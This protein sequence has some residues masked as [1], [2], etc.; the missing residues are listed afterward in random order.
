V[1]S[2]SVAERSTRS[3]AAEAPLTLTEEPPRSLSAFDQA[4]LW[5]N[6]G[7]TLTLPLA[8]LFVV[9]PI[10]DQPALSIV[11]AAVAIVVGVGLG[12]IVLG[13]S[14]VPGADTGAPAMVVLRGLL[15]RW[16]SVV[17]TAAN[18]A[19][20]VGWA[21]VE[22]F[23]IAVAAHGIYDS[24]PK[25]AYIVMAGVAATLLA[26]R[27]LGFIRS[28]RRYA[29]WLIL[30][31]TAYLFVAVI[32]RGL[33]SLTDGS[34]HQF[35]LAVDIAIALPI[36]WAPLAADYS[37]HSRSAAAAFGGTTTG[38]AVAATA[39]FMLGV[40]ALATLPGAAD[41]PIAALLAVPAGG[42]AIAILA[43]DEVDEAFANIYSTAM[44]M[45]NLAGRLDRRLL[46][47]AF[48]ALATGLGLVTDITRYENFLFLIGSVFIPLYAVL[49]IDY[50][51][52][53]RRRR[54]DVSS[55]APMRWLPALPW[56][57]GFVT[58]QL[59]NPGTVSWWSGWW[60]DV[61]N[62]LGF[63]PPTWLSASMS[64]FAVAALATLLLAPLSRH[65]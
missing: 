56:A 9:Q 16:G 35:W 54:W 42:L 60:V 8:A 24:I 57:A 25:S 37:R 36:S 1:T 64:S 12:S 43:I 47:L 7:I 50:F 3:T 6:L 40:L 21:A 17:P 28:I 58:Y 38:Y 53:G 31:A 59:V 15:G 4:A 32:S 23:V 55:S 39:Y 5:G 46:A 30:A 49:V 19:Q 13:L 45:Q 14:A 26:L 2:T 44:S 11:A 51:A 29:V 10:A 61:Q 22:V 41:D 65:R 34:W 48:G 63:T 27:P 20:C 18:L 52:L 62:S 33:P